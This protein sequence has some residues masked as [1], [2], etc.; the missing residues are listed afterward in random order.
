MILKDREDLANLKLP[1]R[2]QV[3]LQEWIA[4]LYYSS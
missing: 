2:M 1:Q 3:E 4:F